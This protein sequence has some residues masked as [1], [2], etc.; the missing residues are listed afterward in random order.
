M[1]EEEL[2]ELDKLQDELTEE[3]LEQEQDLVKVD[4][5]S[6]YTIKDVIDRKAEN[7]RHDRDQN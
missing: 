5:R 2:A 1:T 6:I 4:N 7:A 3:E